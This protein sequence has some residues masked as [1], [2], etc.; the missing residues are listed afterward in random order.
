MGVED[1]NKPSRQKVHK[2]KVRNNI[3]V[4]TGDSCVKCEG[5]KGD[6]K[7]LELHHIDP[8]IKSF[9]LSST[10]IKSKS[11][12][13]VSNE[14][15][16]CIPLCPNCHRLFHLERWDYK[17]L[18]FSKLKDYQVELINNYEHTNNI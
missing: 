13:L 11:W 3:F 15:K 12:A 2:D 6:V 16:K 4:I 17:D 10:I 8:S 9:G 7:M 14:V 1:I 5:F 18:D